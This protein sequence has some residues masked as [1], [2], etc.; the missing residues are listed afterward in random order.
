[1]R[2]YQWPFSY[3]NNISILSV[4][5]RMGQPL[6]ECY[7]DDW[8]QRLGRMQ[9]ILEDCCKDLNLGTETVQHFFNG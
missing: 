6:R 9:E 3:V 1:M 2:P 5:D 4:W 7:S 8:Y